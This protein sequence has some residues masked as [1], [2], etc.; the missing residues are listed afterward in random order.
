MRMRMF[1]TQQDVHPNHI[2]CPAV[3]SPSD[4]SD[5][6][7]RVD[8]SKF[9]QVV[10]LEE[11]ALRSPHLEKVSKSW[12]ALSSASAH[13][14]CAAS[15]CCETVCICCESFIIIIIIIIK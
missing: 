2:F 7:P 10:P 9:H 11:E 12:G 4:S 1:H 3:T 5:F 14:F 15:A 13:N 8:W 6:K